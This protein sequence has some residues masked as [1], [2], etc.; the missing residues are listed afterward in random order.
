[1]NF[2]RKLSSTKEQFEDE[3]VAML[4]KNLSDSEEQA[5][6]VQSSSINVDMKSFKISIRL[7]CNNK[8]N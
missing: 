6:Y 1:L 3:M 2:F 4:R 5:K 7:V 8:T